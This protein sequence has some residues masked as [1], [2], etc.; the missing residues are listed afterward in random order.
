MVVQL[1]TAMEVIMLIVPSDGDS[2]GGAGR[3]M[4]TVAILMEVGVV[5]AALVVNGMGQ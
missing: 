5:L 2:D 1:M 3:W 4:G